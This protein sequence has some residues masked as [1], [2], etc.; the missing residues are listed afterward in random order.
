MSIPAACAGD[1]HSALLQTATVK[2][3]LSMGYHVTVYQPPCILQAWISNN[4]RSHVKI[5]SVIT[6][7]HKKLLYPVCSMLK[8]LVISQITSFCVCVCGTGAQC[9][10]W[11]PHSWSF[12]ITHNNAPQSVGLLWTSYQLVAETST[13]QHATLTGDRH[14]WPRRNSNP[15]S[16]QAS[17]CRPAP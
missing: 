3:M 10:L 9:R 8:P 14:P 5:I 12:Y 11:S 7:C 15:Q 6:S 13:W 17:G 1:M 2:L 16:Q 4:I